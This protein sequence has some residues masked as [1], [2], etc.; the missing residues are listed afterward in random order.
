MK[1]NSK[2][3]SSKSAAILPRHSL[4]SAVSMGAKKG[5]RREMSP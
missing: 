3:V 5:N 4:P 2:T 1:K